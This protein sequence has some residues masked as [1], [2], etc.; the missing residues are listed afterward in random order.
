MQPDVGKNEDV[1]DLQNSPEKVMPRKALSE[2]ACRACK[3]QQ[4]PALPHFA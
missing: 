1:F 2:T 4:Y 3:S